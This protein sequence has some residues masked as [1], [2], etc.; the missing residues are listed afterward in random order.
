MNGDGLRML[1]DLL[2]RLE[3][4][5]I[6]CKLHHSRD[7]AIMVEVAVPGQR[8]EIELVDYGDEFR[9]EIERFVSIGQIEDDTVLDEL[10]A[11]FSDP[12]PGKQE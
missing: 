10:F 12:E 5:G 8:W 11:R 3:Q 4:S 9:W 2:R 1:L 7:D 6:Y